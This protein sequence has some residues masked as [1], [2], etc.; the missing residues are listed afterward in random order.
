MSKPDLDT[1]LRYAATCVYGS[2][3]F[4]DTAYL[5]TLATKP[6]WTIGH[7]TT[8]ID[9]KSVRPGTFCTRQ[10]ADEW[11][12]ADM[13]TTGEEVLALVHVDINEM[14]TASLISLA[15]NIGIGAFERSS[16]LEALNLAMFSLAAN[17]M[18][19]YDEAGH[20]V[21]QGLVTRRQR[22]RALF[23]TGMGRAHDEYNLRDKLALPAVPSPPAVMPE[24]VPSP[25]PDTSADALNAAQL[26]TIKGN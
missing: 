19:E 11:A 8:C 3:G 26:A 7:G 23:L 22:E 20:R 6:V 17:L 13:R 24:G 2:E 21:V 16:V 14:E 1:A 5:D 25:D 12:M 18:L 10:Q 9:G 15:Y 4:R